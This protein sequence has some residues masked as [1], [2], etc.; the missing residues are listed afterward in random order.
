MVRFVAAIVIGYF[1]MLLVI[2]GMFALAYPLFGVDVLFE[3]GSYHAGAGWIIM[4]FIIG[5]VAAISAGQAA[6]RI[7][8]ATQAP[9]WLAAVV[10]VLGGLMAVPVAMSANATR[11]GAR[12]AEVS[13]SDAMAHAEQPLWAA[14]LTPLVSAAGV[15]IGAGPPNRRK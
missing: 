6:T 13:M 2:V 10:L 3:P 5:L 7:A 11:G 1:V 15:L 8:P 12:P 4:S 9:L 14:L